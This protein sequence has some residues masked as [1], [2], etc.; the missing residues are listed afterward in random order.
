[1]EQLK[2]C[3]LQ[4]SVGLAISFLVSAQDQSGL[5]YVSMC[6]ICKFVYTERWLRLSLSVLCCSGFISIDCG[7][8]K[9]SSY[10]DSVTGIKYISDANFTETGVSKS[11]SSDFNTTTLPQ[12][13]WYVRSFPEGERNCFIIKLAQGKGF[14]YL[15]RASFMYGNYDGEGKAPVFDLYMGVNKWDSVVLNNESSII[16]KEVI[17]ALPTSSI[18]ICL[19]N[20]GFGSPF[21]SSLEFRLLKNASYVTDFE[22]LALYRRLD[23][24]STTNKTVR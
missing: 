18:C 6:S 23:V 11:I 4:I 21:I 10:T 3:L 1:M 7:I 22:L 5:C 24:G 12:Q 13:F 8:P 16:T 19:V 17:H 20:T 9:N 15:I 2:Y 14:K